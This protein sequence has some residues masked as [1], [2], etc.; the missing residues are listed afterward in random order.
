MSLSLPWLDADDYEFPSPTTA[1]TIPNGLLAAGGDLHPARLLRAYQLGIFPWYNDDQPLLWWA[2]DPR[3]VLF[4]S[5]LHVSR[6]LAKVLKSKHFTVSSDR[7]F[8]AVLAGCAGPRPGSEGTW[9]TAAMQAAYLQLHQLGHAHSV[10]VWQGATLVGGVYGIAL[11]RI[12]YGES[13]FSHVSNA[14]KV[15]L[16][17]LAR[18]LAQADY[19]LIDCQVASAHLSSLGARLLSRHDFS[20]YLPPSVCISRPARWPIQ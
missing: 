20:A 1:L 2:P 12:F 11:E 7:A 16:T 6:S 18:A 14:S 9:L 5:E 10:E 13:M 17:V 19:R 8:A 3:M 4:P 15:A